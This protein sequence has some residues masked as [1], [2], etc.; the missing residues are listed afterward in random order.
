MK[1]IVSGTFETQYYHKKLP[2]QKSNL[3]YFVPKHLCTTS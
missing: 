3:T 1:S 2:K